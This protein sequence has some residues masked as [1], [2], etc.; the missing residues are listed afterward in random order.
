MA[1]ILVLP[2]F[3]GAYTSETFPA[4]TVDSVGA[5]VLDLTRLAWWSVTINSVASQGTGFQMQQSFN[6]GALWSNFGSRITS[7]GSFDSADGPFALLRIGAG[8]VSSGSASVRV[9]G[10]PVP[11]TW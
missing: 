3:G 8:S 6:G 9:V 7:T 5:D 2:G 1:A 4:T 11:I 10:W